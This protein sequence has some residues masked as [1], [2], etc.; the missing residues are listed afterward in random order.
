MLPRA[1][2]LPV[3]LDLTRAIGGLGLKGADAL[4]AMVGALYSLDLAHN[5]Q[6]D[7]PALVVRARVAEPS[8]ARPPAA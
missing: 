4:G 3:R 7:E 2:A 1:G 8:P 6:L 5:A